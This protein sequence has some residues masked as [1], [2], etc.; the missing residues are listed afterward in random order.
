MYKRL[1]LWGNIILLV[2]IVLA[3]MKDTFRPWMPY[4]RKYRS[5]QVAAE[6]AEEA[7]KIIA[8]RPIEIKQTILVPLGNVDRCITCHQG[9]DSLA[10]P[11][12]TNN[13]SENPYKSHPGDFLKN[14]PP[15]KFGCVICHGGQGLATDFVD[16]GHT[17]KDDAQRAEWKKKY[18]WE[19]AEHW[20]T[21]MLRPPYTQAACVKCHGNFQSLKGEEIVAKGKNLLET[22][23]CMGCHQWH[24]EGGPISVDLAEETTNKPLTRIDFSHTG[25][26]A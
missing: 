8:S 4:Q 3:M 25:L 6:P 12:L 13:F 23:G 9:M 15:D 21:P 26:D 17:P 22:H 5:M 18:H 7:K 16:A 10:T 11:N 1:F 24:G 2:L 14:H 19:P 20:E